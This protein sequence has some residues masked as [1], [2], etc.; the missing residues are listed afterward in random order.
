[1]SIVRTPH[2]GRLA[3]GLLAAAMAIQTGC[4]D[5]GSAK[6]VVPFDDGSIRGQF[7]ETVARFDDETSASS[8]ELRVRGAD[9]D[10]RELVVKLEPDVM[11]NAQVKV[12]G[13][14]V[15]SK[16]FV[17]RIEPD[18]DEEIDSISQPL[19]G[20]P[21][22]AP[23]KLAMAI[24]DIGTG[25]SNPMIT[26]AELQNR[27]FTN[28]NSTRALYL[29]NS[30]QMQD[31]SGK[32]VGNVLS[33]PM[34]TCDTGGMA[35]SLKAMV[36]ADVGQTSNIY[37]WYFQGKASSCSWS[38]LSSGNNTYYNAS[39]GCVVLAQEP[40]HSLG[41]AHASSMACTGGPF[42]DDP[43][44][45]C[46]HNE[47]GS[48]Y[49]TMGGGCRHLTAYHKVYRT[50]TQKCNVVR[51][52]KSGTFNLFP[53]EKPCNGIQ[54]LAV[55][56]AHVRPFTNSGGGGGGARNT[57]LAYYTVEFRSPI[58][59]DMGMKPS[60]L[61]N[62][63]P[64]FKFN[65][66]PSR[67]NARGEHTWILDMNSASTSTDGTG[68]ALLPG[69]TFTDPAGGIS[70][71]TVSVT[72]DGAVIKVDISGSSTVDG[73]VGDTVCIDN[74]P[75]SAPGPATCGDD[76]GSPNWDASIPDTGS[77]GTGGRGGAGGGGGRGGAAG[78][79]GGP[80]TG[81]GAGAG[82]GTTTGAG[83][84]TTGST[85]SSTTGPG[86]TTSGAT[87]GGTTS[88]S[89]TGGAGSKG[90]GGLDGGC[91]CRVQGHE[92]NSGGR[93]AIV[94]LGLGLVGLARRRRKDR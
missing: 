27:I 18:L 7:I 13:Q 14:K 43:N 64:D 62:A 68:N 16:I 30:Y 76:G 56:M 6:G 77:P 71:T 92:S 39:S 79:G 81:G 85:S 19:I 2:G 41:L 63:S 58:G 70:I 82:G 36:D 65:N 54:V 44:N 5:Q 1:M 67:G 66:Q 80:A 35:S 72:P 34:S 91:A 20:T 86:S 94:M 74:T 75:I 69:Q 15:G 46:T 26:P 89:T 57:Q 61:I 60:V 55:P 53:T 84:S 33:Y 50:Y 51:V 83:G 47:Y 88:G 31:I 78:A 90:D 11:P 48:R 49:D 40:Y 24:I 32:V 87:T 73:G 59:F 12:W 52:R 17:D 10:V 4:S 25:N 8:Y 21:P 38:G 23:L 3:L 29:E 45:G 93:G 22:L 37:L 9:H 42:A 28:A